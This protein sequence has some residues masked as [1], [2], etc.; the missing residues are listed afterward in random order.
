[1]FAE[2]TAVHPLQT[3]D[4]ARFRELVLGGHGPIAVEFMSYGCAHCRALEPV[5]Q[6]VA[7]LVSPG[8]T[9][10]RVNVAVDQAL[11][12]EYSIAGTPTLVMFLESREVGRVAG[13]HPTVASVMAA[14]TAPF[15][16]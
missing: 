14:V 6:K 10:Y 1:M 11:A 2:K 12:A 7:E 15:S 9:I 13:P 4:A 8:E 16:S 5:L 3:V